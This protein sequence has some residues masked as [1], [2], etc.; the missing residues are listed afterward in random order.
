MPEVP[1]AAKTRITEMSANKQETIIGKVK[2]RLKEK[3]FGHSL[4]KERKFGVSGV[5]FEPTPPFG[6]RNTRYHLDSKGISP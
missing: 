5:G 2:E 1:P 4:K 3:R 6:D